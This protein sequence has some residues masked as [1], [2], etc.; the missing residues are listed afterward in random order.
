MDD[1]GWRDLSCYGSAFYETPRIDALAREGMLFSDAYAACPVC[2]PSRASLMTG[3]Y[4]ARVGVTDWLDHSGHNHPLKGKL[5]DAPYSHCLPLT[6]KT[7]AS[8]LRDGGYATW[9][10]GK[11]HLGMEPYWPEHHGFDVNIGGCEW[12]YPVGGYFSPYQNPRLADGPEGEYLIDRLTDEAISLIRNRG[13]DTP[14]FLYMSHYA[15]HEPVEAKAEDIA[16]FEKKARRLGLDRLPVF[17]IGEN[18]PCGSD[19]PDNHFIGA[20]KRHVV[21]RRVQSDPVYAAMIKSLDGNTGRLLDALENEG[22]G[23][24]TIVIFTSDNGGFS[25]YLE[26]YGDTPTCNAPLA[27][28]KGWMYDG[29]VREPLIIRWP[30]VIRAGSTCGE[31]VTTPDF[32]PTLLD[33]AGLPPLPLQH[34]DGMSMIDALYEKPFS[35]GPVFWHYPH[36]GNQGGTPGA[37]VREGD[38]KLI[39]FF[40]DGRIELYNLKDDISETNNLSGVLPEKAAE[41]CAKLHIWMKDAGAIQ[42]K[43][44]PGWNR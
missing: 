19:D 14:F 31:P 26:G 16:Y 29:G 37:A 17:E 3:K 32:Y 40:E 27:E 28:G 7:I 33:A 34:V 15:V 39:E 18:W 6:E 1:L 42:P 35:R 43:Q 9:H 38:F 25:S 11:W 13:M 4:P 41:L 5:I 36:Y 20:E 44:N 8:A 12:G 22:I 24:N 23:G 2:S 10:L 21:R 30:S